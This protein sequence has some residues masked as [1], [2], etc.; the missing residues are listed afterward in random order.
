[1]NLKN[2]KVKVLISVLR[3]RGGFHEQESR[4]EEQHVEKE[5]GEEK[6]SQTSAVNSNISRFSFTCFVIVDFSQ[7][8]ICC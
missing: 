4:E 7:S 2:E 1:M 6:K 8:F 5:A 3:K